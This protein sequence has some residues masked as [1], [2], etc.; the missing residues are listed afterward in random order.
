MEG[1]A[2]PRRWRETSDY[3][4]W[5]RSVF[6][7]Y[8]NECAITRLKQENSEGKTLVIHHLYGAKDYPNL[9]YVVENG[10]VLEKSIHML[11][12]NT[13]GSPASAANNTIQQF[14][15]FLSS[16]LLKETLE[17]TSMPISSQ[18]KPEGLEG[19]E[20]RAYD[21]DRVMKLQERLERLVSELDI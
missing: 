9:T 21:P 20:T 3:A 5:R 4:K 6:K 7:V 2:K 1:A 15:T 11:F 14:L 17:K 19:P 16:P 8:N 12:H 18:A 13:Y 10:I